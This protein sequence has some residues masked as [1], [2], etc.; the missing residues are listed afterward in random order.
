MN[1]F[2]SGRQQ[3]QQQA[4]GSQGQGHA[5]AKANLRAWWNQF[6]FVKGMKKDV[7][8]SQEDYAYRG[9]SRFSV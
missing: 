4:S 3:Q 6:N 2:G 9:E 7:A 5:A 8:A 1:T